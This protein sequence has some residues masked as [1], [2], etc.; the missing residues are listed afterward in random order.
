MVQ[1]E[2]A[3]AHARHARSNSGVLTWW[4]G[5]VLFAGI[6]L[7]T[8]GA[9]NAIEGL[10]ALFNPDYY[11]AARSQLTGQ[12]DYRVY[13]WTLLVF[14]VLLASAGYGLMAGRT[15]A[16]VIGV[17]AAVI[18]GF[19]NFAFMAAYP[20]WTALTMTLDVVVIYAL[21]V[22]GREVKLL[23]FDGS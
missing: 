12:V 11:R 20:L 8:A 14:G 23:R 3:P 18:S 4:V 16:R 17:I 2:G 15:W 19:T 21:I 6:A 7:F 22:H 5:W 10:V 1:P 9:F 13:G